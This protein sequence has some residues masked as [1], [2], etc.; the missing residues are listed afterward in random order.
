MASRVNVGIQRY[1]MPNVYT[2]S[3]EAYKSSIPGAIGSTV[4]KLGNAIAARNAA[5][6]IAAAQANKRNSAIAKYRSKTGDYLEDNYDKAYNLEFGEVTD[7]D[8]KYDPFKEDDSIISDDAIISD[9]I[10]YLGDELYV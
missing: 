3:K 4:D 9:D 6:R 8:K 10:R 5:E 2:M 7:E 1:N